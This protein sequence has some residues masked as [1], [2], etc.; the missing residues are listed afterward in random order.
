MTADSGLTVWDPFGKSAG[1]A[2]PMVE[3]SDK[4][5]AFAP[6]TAPSPA[7]PATL[8]AVMD[9]YARGEDAAF[10]E[11]YRRGAPRLRGFLLR[12][13]GDPAL[14]DD[15]TQEA[16]LRVHRARGNF[17]AGAAALPWMLAIAR[18]AFLDQ[19]RRVKTRRAIGDR[20]GDS[21][22]TA[23]PEAPASGRGDEVL[24]AREMLDVVRTTLDSIPPLHR[25]A[26]VLLRF[27]GLS[28]GEAAQVVG[29]TEGAVKIRAFRAYEAIR[30]ALDAGGGRGAKRP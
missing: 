5:A 25:E 9:R 12:L 17:A 13:C 10:D 30:A 1:L 11:L 16:F 28:V 2:F 26:F 21:R 7:T 8:D 6:V 23:E 22:A 29:A 19:A 24:A 18:N 20:P 14:A 15:L 4:A 27:E 3:S